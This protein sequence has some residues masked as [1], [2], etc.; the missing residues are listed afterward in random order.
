MQKD[1]S[2]IK[3]GANVTTFKHTNEAA[4]EAAATFKELLKDENAVISLSEKFGKSNG[5]ISFVINVKRATGEVESLRYT[6]L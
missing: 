5:L 4:R 2:L 1:E 3:T 6:F